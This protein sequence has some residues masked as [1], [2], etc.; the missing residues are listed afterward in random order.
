MDHEETMHMAQM[1]GK[2]DDLLE[3]EE[4]EVLEA[5]P[6]LSSEGKAK[7]KETVIQNDASKTSTSHG[8][9]LLL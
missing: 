8:E 9:D 4:D 5:G 2:F 1:S 3:E 7:S 6:A